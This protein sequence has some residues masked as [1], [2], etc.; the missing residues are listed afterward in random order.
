MEEYPAMDSHEV[1]TTDMLVGDLHG[2]VDSELAD[3]TVGSDFSN[4]ASIR[5]N[6]RFVLES[7]TVVSESVPS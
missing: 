2:D 3:L 7:W 1:A 6:G 4:W 5:L